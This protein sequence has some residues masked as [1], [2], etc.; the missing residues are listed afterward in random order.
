MF[1]I[2]L[3]VGAWGLSFIMFSMYLLL[4]LYLD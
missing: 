3:D 2:V 1:F 4:T